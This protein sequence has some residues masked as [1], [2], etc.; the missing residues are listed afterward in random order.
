MH[1]TATFVG[2]RDVIVTSGSSVA[3]LNTITAS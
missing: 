3:V 1:F 2:I